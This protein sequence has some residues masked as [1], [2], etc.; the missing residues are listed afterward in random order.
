MADYSKITER[1]K[2]I[3]WKPIADKALDVL[4]DT[5]SDELTELSPE[6]RTRYEA[7]VMDV[8]RLTILHMTANQ[9]ER[10][11]IEN[12]MGF[13]KISMESM[14]ARNNLFSYR[15]T[16]EIIGAILA[17]TIAVALAVA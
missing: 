6:D 11:L 1:L 13:V 4:K 8:A 5:S 16:V 12:E 14:E 15:K 9:E 3:D 10:E 7:A 17:A 2:E